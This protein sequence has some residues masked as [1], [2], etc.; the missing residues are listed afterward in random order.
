MKESVLRDLIAKDVCKLKPGL[1]LLQKEQY[2]PNKHGTKG[3]I[4]LYA[5]DENNHHVLI[6]LKR[7]AAASRQA[8][9]EVSKYI[10]GVKQYLGAKD[11]EIVVIIASTDWSEL[12]VPFSYFTEKASV[13]VEGVEIILDESGDQF[14]CKEKVPLSV[15]QGRYFTPWHNIYLYRSRESLDAGTESIKSSYACK[16]ISDYVIVSFQKIA[17][18][19]TL[20]QSSQY[21][22][23]AYTATQLFSV[24]ECMSIIEKDG[25]LL[26]DAEETIQDLDEEEA[27]SYLHECIEILAPSPSHDSYEI[28]YP[29][30]FCSIIEHGQYEVVSLLRFGK[31]ERNALLTDDA[32]LAEL[33]G[34][35]GA[36][37]QRFKRKIKVSDDKAV[38]ELKKDVSKALV[39]NPVWKRHLQ[40]IVDEITVEYP[41]SE[42]EIWIYNPSTGVFTIYY[43]MTSQHGELYIPSYAALVKNPEVIRMYFGGLQENGDPLPF[44]QILSKYYEDD[45]T[46]LLA[47]MLWGGTEDRDGEIVE[48]LGMQYRSFRVDFHEENKD[49]SIW[50]D[51]RW[52]DCN[53]C[54]PIDLFQDYVEKNATFVRQIIRQIK[55]YMYGEPDNS[56]A[57]DDVVAQY[58]SPALQEV[59][60]QSKY[61]TNPP[62]T[63]DICKE[64]LKNRRFMIDGKVR[65]HS[66]W[67]CMCSDCFLAVGE[68]ITWGKGQLY[69]RDPQ[70]WRLV[71]GEGPQWEEQE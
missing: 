14:S 58:I 38:R 2:I 5:K 1:T 52:R 54:T 61:Y 8:L 64:P 42:I 55:P 37:G 57:A 35:D 50:K 53:P 22:F 62:D 20:D 59:G 48:D 67:A 45:L 21:P 65:G 71:G 18:D 56:R 69:Q 27:L 68:E 25:I 34:E 33:R 46:A 17:T 47:T 43:P 66:A 19:G 4:D 39:L 7:S 32:I 44:P 30:K 60:A 23:I 49:F 36:V 24:D 12:L 29:A 6:E 11:S 10:E 63:C 15:E 70:G 9:H 16:G 28:G 13:H 51:E 41:N 40:Q 3:F 26:N 31:F